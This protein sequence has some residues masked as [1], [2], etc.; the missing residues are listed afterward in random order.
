MNGVKTPKAN[1]YKHEHTYTIL[2]IFHVNL[3]HQNVKKILDF[4]A[5]KKWWTWQAKKQYYENKC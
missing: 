4:D 5:A 2:T 3:A 1:N